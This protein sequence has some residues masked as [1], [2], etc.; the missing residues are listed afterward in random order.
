MINQTIDDLKNGVYKDGYYNYGF[1]IKVTCSNK[2]YEEV[3]K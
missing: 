1:E 2:T 3:F